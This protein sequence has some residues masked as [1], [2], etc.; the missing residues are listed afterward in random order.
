MPAALSYRGMVRRK[1]TWLLVG[2]V[3]LAVGGTAL[4]VSRGPSS[5]ATAARRNQ[6]PSPLLAVIGASFSAG[7]GA[8]GQHRAWPEDLAK[9]LHWRL[10]LSADPGA[11]YV[12][13]GSGRRGPLARLAARLH[14][15]RASPTLIIIQGGH[16]DIG[17]PPSLIRERVQSLVARIHRQAPHSLL[18][19]LTVFARG[20]RPSAAAM[21]TDR[22][23][24]AAARRADPA[25]LVFDPLADGWHFPRG[26]DHLHPTAAGYRWIARDLAADLRRLLD[27]SGRGHAALS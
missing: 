12:N 19:V 4:T 21:A 11:G 25:I 27:V 5:V 6:T 13:R 23:I 8:G 7:V 22:A 18:A 24:V 26:G 14:L 1:R 10:V 3:V 2:L 17:R 16:D 9:T 20:N 15:G